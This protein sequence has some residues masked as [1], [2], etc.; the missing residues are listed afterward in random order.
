MWIK[1]K[2]DEALTQSLAEEPERT[3][4]IWTS[5]GI[6]ATTRPGQ[7][8]IYTKIHEIAAEKKEWWREDA[9]LV[10]FK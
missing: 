2:Q 8:I 6:V 1:V 7:K 9:P 4:G 5:L 3:V 10:G